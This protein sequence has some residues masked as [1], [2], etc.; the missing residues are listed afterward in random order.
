MKKLLNLVLASGLVFCMDITNVVVAQNPQDSL[1]GE[2]NCTK[3]IEIQST[4]YYKNGRQVEDADDLPGCYASI[5]DGSTVFSNTSGNGQMS[6][7]VGEKNNDENFRFKDYAKLHVKDE[8]ELNVG[9]NV[10]LKVQKDGKLINRGKI[11]LQNGSELV[12]PQIDEYHITKNGRVKHGIDNNGGT[13]CI[14]TGSKIHGLEEGGMATIYEGVVDFENFFDYIDSPSNM[15]PKGNFVIGF[16]RVG[17]RLFDPVPTKEVTNERLERITTFSNILLGEG[18]TLLDFGSLY[19]LA[20]VYRL[21]KDINRRNNLFLSKGT[22]VRGTENGHNIDLEHIQNLFHEGSKLLTIEGNSNNNNQSSVENYYLKDLVKEF[23]DKNY[24]GA[25]IINT[26]YQDKANTLS[27]SDTYRDKFDE[28]LTQDWQEKIIDNKE[29]PLYSDQFNETDSDGN[30]LFDMYFSFEGDRSV[31]FVLNDVDSD[32]NK[33]KIVFHNKFSDET[34]KLN[35]DVNNNTNIV[36]KFSQKY[37]GLSPVLQTNENTEYEVLTGDNKNSATLRLVADTSN[38]ACLNRLIIGGKE[39]AKFEV[40]SDSQYAQNIAV[41]NL[42]MRCNSKAV[43]KAGQ[44]LTIGGTTVD[45]IPENEYYDDEPAQQQ[46]EV[47][48]S[49]GNDGFD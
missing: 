46:P 41:N 4:N 48:S 3:N 9:N 31:S 17:I 36:N 10:L 2:T 16:N 7:L 14:N 43:F 33:Y 35:I 15:P 12:A 34:P 22:I 38:N 5:Q 49:D 40:D 30:K 32:Y 25:T 47:V 42:E 39:K 21:Q 1:L 29:F 26:N 8:T 13:I 20:G 19:G 23:N 6:I 45:S 24:E 11:I 27:K 28:K 18:C 44:I 37:V